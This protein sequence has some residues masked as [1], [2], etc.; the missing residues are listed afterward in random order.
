MK[1]QALVADSKSVQTQIEQLRRRVEEIQSINVNLRR[2]ASPFHDETVRLGTEYTQEQRQEEIQNVPNDAEH[3]TTLATIHNA[4]ILSR[5]STP[6]EEH[7]KSW[8][9]LLGHEHSSREN[10]SHPV[11]SSE[12]NMAK[13]FQM[14]QNQQRQT[15]EMVQMIHQNQEQ[16]SR[17]LDDLAL[18]TQPSIAKAGQPETRA[19]RMPELNLGSNTATERN[20][21]THQPTSEL[22]V[23]F[24]PNDDEPHDLGL[25]FDVPYGDIR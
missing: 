25:K 6:D 19:F 14:M 5:H 3:G 2:S 4:P 18:N 1:S 7:S 9:H 13:M 8:E 16:L 23:G 11:S 24:Q 12:L 15:A 22:H 10:S 20:R 17:R 21:P